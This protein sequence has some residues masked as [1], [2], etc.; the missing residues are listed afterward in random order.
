MLIASSAELFLL[1]GADV[2]EITETVTT[3]ISK[4]VHDL[5][6]L[7]N[8]IYDI[9]VMG[10][11]KKIELKVTELPN[12]MKILSYLGGEL[13]NSSTYFSTFGNVKSADSNDFRKT[14]GTSK[15][16]FWKA[17]PYEKRVSDAEKAVGKYEELGKLNLE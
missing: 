14:F 13:S 15:T 12:D 17:F 6:I 10:Q 11:I 3:F 16:N 9:S 2:E 1:F 7:E 8:K 5:E 4:L